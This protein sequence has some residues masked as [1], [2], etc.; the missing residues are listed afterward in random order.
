MIYIR[1]LP[2]GEP[3]RSTKNGALMTLDELKNS[4]IGNEPLWQIGISMVFTDVHVNRAPIPGTVRLVHHRPGKFLSLRLEEALDVNERQTLVLAGN[5]FEI[6]LV[7]IASRLVRQIVSY[8]KEGEGLE[9]AQRIG[10]IRFGSQVDL[11]LPT[12]YCKALDVT[13]G[14]KLVAGE[15]KICTSQPH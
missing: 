3:L 13:V 10:M 4:R 8:V 2:A 1:R 11:F 12:A 14:D 9:H 5:E 6:A 7:Q 15:T